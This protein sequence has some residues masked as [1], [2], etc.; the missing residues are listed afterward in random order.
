MGSLLSRPTQAPPPIQAPSPPA[1]D[2]PDKPDLFSVVE[3]G[4]IDALLQLFQDGKV[5]LTAINEDSGQTALHTAIYAGHA[6]VVDILLMHAGDDPRILCAPNRHGQT[7]LMCAAEQHDVETMK[8]LITA[9]ATSSYEPHPDSNI[10]SARAKQIAYETHASAE[11]LVQTKGDIAEAFELAVE[12]RNLFA[13][14]LFFTGVPDSYALL[15][16][17]FE[18]RDMASLAWMIGPFARENDAIRILENAVNANDQTA[19]DAVVFW[20]R[21]DEA[22][23]LL[24]RYAL[25]GDEAA[26]R[27]LLASS[28]NPYIGMERIAETPDLS[29]TK[30]IE[31]MKL[32]LVNAR[33]NL[34]LLKSYCD[35]MVERLITEDKREV[36]RLMIACGLDAT[37]LVAAPKARHAAFVKI[38][39]MIHAE[40]DN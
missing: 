22:T 14:K 13:A 34:E 1:P 24:I 32:I 37:P 35:T 23:T 3:D 11:M 36:M 19:I 21:S 31:A 30:K 33:S 16:K 40:R 17:R 15:Q 25:D 9:G 18:Q 27:A 29:E 12:Q 38:F 26:M 7:P 2:Q 28:L 4:D 20:S 10:V 6:D 39:D 5:D 8:A